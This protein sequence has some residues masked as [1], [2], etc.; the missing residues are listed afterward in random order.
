MKRLITSIS[1]II[2]GLFSAHAQFLNAFGISGGLTL[3]RQKW[4]FTPPEQSSFAQKKNFLFG[5]NG[6]VFAEFLED[7]NY[8]WISELEFNQKGCR[9]KTEGNFKNRL[10]YIS[11]NNY[12]KYKWEIYQGFPYFLAGPKLEYL[13][14]Q[15]LE[16]PPL[17]ASFHHLHGS[18]DLGAG[19]EWI[20]F[21]PFKFFSELH[22]NPDVYL[23]AYKTD[24]L[25][26]RNRAWEIRVGVKYQRSRKKESCNAPVYVK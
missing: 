9:D 6:S 21:Y 24:Y 17:A 10:Q 1:F 26:A 3:A 5:F 8:R 15:S 18:L 19:F 11:W 22:Y 16:S 13:F 4:L 23:K 14:S 2:I 12:L 25:V 7:E 20:S